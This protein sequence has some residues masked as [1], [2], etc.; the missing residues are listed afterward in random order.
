ME[1]IIH[2]QR[3]ERPGRHF[4]ANFSIDSIKA[5]I[6]EGEE[7]AEDTLIGVDAKRQ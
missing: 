5:L 3:N 7:D 2:K 6:K 1:K 4:D